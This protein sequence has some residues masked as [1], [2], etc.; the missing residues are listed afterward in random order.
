MVDWNKPLH[1]SKPFWFRSIL[2]IIVS[3][4]IIL[5]STCGGIIGGLEY[6][7]RCFKGEN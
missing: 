2:T 6:I 3:P 7:F 1:K 4:L 5:F